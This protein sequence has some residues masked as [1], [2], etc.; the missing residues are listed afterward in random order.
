MVKN[1]IVII[2]FLLV[3]VLFSGLG[4]SIYNNSELKVTNKRLIEN[5]N[6]LNVDNSELYFTNKELNNY[7]KDKDTKHKKEMDS[8][9]K[10]LSIK[11]KNL[12]RY[13]K[14]LVNNLDVDTTMASLNQL[15]IKNDSIYRVD[16]K[17]VRKCLE[18]KGYIESTDSNPKVVIT[19]TEGSNIVYVVKSYKKSFWDVIFFRKGKEII[20]TNSECGNSSV[21]TIEVG[22]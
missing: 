6:K 10:K 9:L 22:Q 8:V 13:E 16:W 17:S 5:L 7:L 15:T 4:Y 1:K 20:Q 21:N 3:I 18:I 2:L 11:P 12:I 14:I 19:E